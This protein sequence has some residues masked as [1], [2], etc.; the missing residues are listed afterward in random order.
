MTSLKVVSHDF[1][2]FF[3]RIFYFGL[4]LLVVLVGASRSPAA[5]SASTASSQSLSPITLTFIVVGLI[6]AVLYIRGMYLVLSYASKTYGLE[7][8]HSAKLDNK[9]ATNLLWFG[10]FL[11]VVSS[12]VIIQAYGFAPWFLYIGPTL[13]LL[14][15]LVIIISME[16][17]LQRY[18]RQIVANRLQQETQHLKSPTE[19]NINPSLER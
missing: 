6:L 13:S 3:K 10:S 9:T 18:K 1:W 14:G 16:V 19:R 8:D 17:D 4:A 7:D 2:T 5:T 11:L 12:A 15:P